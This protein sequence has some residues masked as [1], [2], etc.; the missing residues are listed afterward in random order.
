MSEEA[1]VVG[2]ETAKGR[3]VEGEV[4]ELMRGGVGTDGALKATVALTLRREA[5][6]LRAIC[7]RQ[8]SGLA[9]AGSAHP[10]PG[11]ADAILPPLTSKITFAI[12]P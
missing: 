12:K 9:H 3:V 10:L 6:A 7:P 2:A 1:S 5:T 11:Q 4:T 8:R